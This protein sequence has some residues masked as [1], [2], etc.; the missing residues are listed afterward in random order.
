MASVRR[1]ALIQICIDLLFIMVVFFSYFNLVFE[2]MDNYAMGVLQIQFRFTDSA[3]DLE[4]YVSA[5]YEDFQTYF[6][7]EEDFLEINEICEKLDR[8]KA[9]GIAYVI[10]SCLGHI[11]LAYGILHVVAKMFKSKRPFFLFQYAHCLHLGAYTISLACYLG[12]SEVF[13]LSP[14]SNSKNGSEVKVEVGIFA[15]FIAE[16]LAISSVVFFWVS[17]KRFEEKD[18]AD[19]EKKE[20]V[21]HEEGK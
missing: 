11:S 1:I 6:C 13:T 9:A 15:L 20:K 14:P 7:D 16:I 21:P 12:I 8:F 17:R 2:Y 5:Y 4:A 10:I 18:L 19:E 3:S